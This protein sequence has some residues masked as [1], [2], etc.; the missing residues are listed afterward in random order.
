MLVGLRW[1]SGLGPWREVRRVGASLAWAHAFRSPAPMGRVS[2]SLDYPGLGPG[3]RGGGS[4]NLFPIRLRAA[5][6]GSVPHPAL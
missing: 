4:L 3:T 2:L 5:F 1:T 6:L